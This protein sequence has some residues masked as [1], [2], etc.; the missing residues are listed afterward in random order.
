MV[1][2]IGYRNRVTEL[3]GE[4]E[5]YR[6]VTT[7]TVTE[8]G[9]MLSLELSIGPIDNTYTLIPDDPAL[10]RLTFTTPKP[11]QPAPVEFVRHDEGVDLFVDRNRLHKQ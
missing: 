6:G 5:A 10:H 9:G 11:G 8:E 1:P 7:A 2:A 4:Y 3:V